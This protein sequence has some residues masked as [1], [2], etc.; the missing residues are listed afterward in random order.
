MFKSEAEYLRQEAHGNGGV[1]NNLFQWEAFLEDMVPLRLHAPKNNHEPGMVAGFAR[2]RCISVTMPSGP[3]RVTN[4]FL[5][6]AFHFLA[7]A[8]G[9]W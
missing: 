9:R 8:I 4:A 2:Q 5:A 7:I 3:K 6:A 1:P